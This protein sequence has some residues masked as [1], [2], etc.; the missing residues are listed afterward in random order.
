MYNPEDYEIT[1][2][3]QS[4]RDGSN[5]MIA[6]VSRNIVTADVL[7]YDGLNGNYALI[8]KKITIAHTQKQTIDNTGIPESFTE[9][10]NDPY[11]GMSMLPIDYN[12]VSLFTSDATRKVDFYL[13]YKV[14]GE[15]FDKLIC[16]CSMTAKYS[17]SLDAN[18]ASQTFE[19]E[20]VWGVSIQVNH[21]FIVYQF[22]KEVPVNGENRAWG[23]QYDANYGFESWMV[24]R[25]EHYLWKLKSHIVGLINIADGVDS[26]VGYC[27]EEEYNVGEEGSVLSSG[28]VY[29]VGTI[30]K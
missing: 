24:D 15:K 30:I 6:N 28:E 1:T 10:Y 22:K 21:N 8:W 4:Q 13:T 20:R 19:G 2:V 9:Y 26:A 17:H 16:S 3:K 18:S 14:N 12:T 25:D 29:S 27:K 11:G 23:G 5:S 7:D